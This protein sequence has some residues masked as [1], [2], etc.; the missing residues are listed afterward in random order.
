MRYAVVV[1]LCVVLPVQPVT[2]E[3]FL[4]VIRL[5]LLVYGVRG[6][7]EMLYAADNK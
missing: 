5:G 6:V 2:S 1:S 7:M 4:T 3:F